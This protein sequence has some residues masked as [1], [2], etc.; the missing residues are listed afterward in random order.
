MRLC[1]PWGGGSQQVSV[2]PET[3]GAGRFAALPRTAG[4]GPPP[5]A[6]LCGGHPCPV[7]WRVILG[8]IGR[9]AMS[10]TL[11]VELRA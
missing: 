1:G 8:L 9:Q 10:Q 6:S 11:G 4:N 3:L 7:P 2:G 5:G